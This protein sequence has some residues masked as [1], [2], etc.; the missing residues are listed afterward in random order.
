MTNEGSVEGNFR[1]L[2]NVMGL[3]LEQ[4]CLKT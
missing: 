4:E 1:F 2:K 3:W